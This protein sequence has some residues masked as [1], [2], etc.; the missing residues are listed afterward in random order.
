MLN[1]GS[2][3]RSVSLTSLSYPHGHRSG[4]C[5]PWLFLQRICES[6][7]PWAFQMQPTLT[8][9]CIVKFHFERYHNVN[10]SNNMYCNNL[11]EIHGH[12]GHIGGLTADSQPR[13]SLSLRWAFTL[14]KMV[15][16]RSLSSSP[17]PCFNIFNWVC[18]VRP[19]GSSL[20]IFAYRSVFSIFSIS[21][22]FFLFSPIIPY[23]YDILRCQSWG[24]L[25]W[26]A[27]PFRRLDMTLLKSPY[28][29]RIV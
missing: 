28:Q 6:Q 8:N 24:A 13:R 12:M 16:S 1:L 17:L 10:F 4:R 26:L 22:L 19:F 9:F 27:S 14:A 18:N 2:V 25:T 23:V 5:N 7:G 29:F 11:M 3:R 21:F 20:C 15:R